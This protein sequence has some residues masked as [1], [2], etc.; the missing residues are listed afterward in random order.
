MNG[1]SNITVSEG[2]SIL[3]YAKIPSDLKLLHSVFAA[4]ASEKINIDM[5]SQTAPSDSTVSISFTVPDSEMVKALRLTNE[6]S[7]GRPAL[8][9]PMVSSGNCKIQLAGEEMRHMHGVVS[10]AIGALAK[11]G[12]EPVLITTSEVD[13]S[14]LIA[15]SALED[16]VRALTAA[17]GL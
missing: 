6:I 1:V 10:D 5:V 9:K 15:P 11:A 3:T 13:I 7:K 4:F 14:L 8:T 17:F 12:A 2:V 16:A